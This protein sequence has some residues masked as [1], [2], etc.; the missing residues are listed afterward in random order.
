MRL[1]ISEG[2]RRNDI[3]AANLHPS[4]LLVD[5][6]TPLTETTPSHVLVE[7]VETPVNEPVNSIQEGSVVEIGRRAVSPPGEIVVE[8]HSLAGPSAG[9]VWRLTSG[10]YVLGDNRS[11]SIRLAGCPTFQIEVD[12]QGVVSA[13]GVTTDPAFWAGPHHLQ[14]SIPEPKVLG[15]S[16]P[17]WYFNRPPRPRRADDFAP[18]EAPART[19]IQGRSRR[20]SPITLTV[21]VLTGVFL[22]LVFGRLLFLAF[23]VISPVMMLGNAW[24]DRRRR[25]RETAESEAAFAA[26]FEEFANTV[27]RHQT[28][29]VE[30]RYADAPSLA[31]LVS[32]SD[33]GAVNL[34]ERRPEHDDFASLVVGYGSVRTQIPIAGSANREPEVEELLATRAALSCAPIRVELVE[35]RTLGLIGDRIRCAALARSVVGQAAA[36]HGPSDLRVAVITENTASWDWA[37]W[38]PHTCANAGTD[39]RLLSGSDTEASHILGFLRAAPAEGEPGPLTILVVDD[40]DLDDEQRKLVTAI[41]AGTGRPVAGIIIAGELASLPSRCTTVIDLS[42]AGA[43]MWQPG[44]ANRVERFMTVESRPEIATRL[45]RRMTHLDDPEAVHAGAGLPD[46]VN[47]LALLGMPKPTVADITKRWEGP[48]RLATPVGE[49]EGGSLVLDLIADGPHGLLAGTTGS[50]KSEFLR[51]L[52]AGLASSVDP[53]HLNFVLIDYKGGAAFDV[54]AE[55]PHVVGL[56]T[57]LDEHLGQRALVCLEAELHYREGRLRDAGTGSIDEF[58]EAGAEMP[59]PRLVVV[60]DEFATLAAELPDF[61]DALLDIA[62]RGRS[63]GV[64]MLLATQRPAGIVKDSIRANTNLRL[65]LRVQTRADSTDVLGS[66]DAAKISRS[67]PG[68]GLVRLGPGELIPFQTAMVSGY[69]D[70]PGPLMQIAPFIFGMQQ[71]EIPTPTSRLIQQR[72]TDLARLVEAINDA[73]V[74]S[75]RPDPRRPWPDP[76]P[77]SL[78]PD[79]L[80][81]DNAPLTAPLGLVDL[82]SMQRQDTWCWNPVRDGNL[83][84]AGMPASGPGIAATTALAELARRSPPDELHVYGIDHGSGDLSTLASLPHVGTIVPAGSIERQ[85]RLLEFLRREIEHRRASGRSGPTIVFA[86][87]GLSGFRSSFDDPELVVYRD[88]LQELVASGPARGVYSILTA[89]QARSVPGALAGALPNRLVFSLA[90]RLDYSTLGLG[91]TPPVL[92]VGRAVEARTGRMIQTITA[93]STSI[94]A[95]AQWPAPSLPPDPIATL[96]PDVA[97]PDIIEAGHLGETLWEIPLGVDDRLLQP[98]TVPFYEGDHLLIAG[99]RRS[100][101][102]TALATMAAAVA[103]LDESVRIVAVAGPRSPLVADP[104]I[105]VVVCPTDL[106][107]L[108][109]LEGPTLVLVDDADSVEDADGVLAGLLCAVGS[110]VHVVAAGRSDVIR[111]LPRHWTRAFRSARRGFV[112][113]PADSS[114]GDLLGVRLPRSAAVTTPGRGYLIDGTP[115]LVQIAR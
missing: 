3:V 35:A 67:H 1:S 97:L 21:P 14:F 10:T 78:G 41:L 45:A 15:S 37:K 73:F 46:S 83:L 68:R 49:T 55:L 57:D 101:R 111:S 80:D 94:A 18:I 96:S 59:L 114:D 110:Q 32:R 85:I 71:P 61:M 2:E 17:R 90:D 19:P 79:D 69:G 115:T 8:L 104:N 40:P 87:D 5:V 38:L 16:T 93:T 105:A 75:D 98:V 9:R 11:A 76:L 28:T 53:D 107:S 81:G 13:P 20:L 52:V 26:E 54:C 60:V 23:A 106:E 77:D 74:A 84:L 42:T 31:A 50:G 91:T 24:D 4:T 113:Q 43:S 109:D 30:H 56:V 25:R 103:K 70:G 63:L 108:G 65:S 100:G 88:R 112:L 102:S 62:Q 7:G 64:H 34:W 66:P 36:L 92:G 33:R 82:P 51:T 29:Q 39:V 89:D 86:L 44:R 72:Q 27:E 22:A 99:P 48:P 58:W 47:L 6:I 12:E 95:A